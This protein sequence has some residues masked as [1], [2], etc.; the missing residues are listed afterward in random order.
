M[1]QDWQTLALKDLAE[2]DLSYKEIGEKYGRDRDTVLNLRRKHNVVRKLPP[3]KGLR[4]AVEIKQL[5]PE[6]RAL[7]VRLSIYR[8]VRN[9]SELAQE[10]N[11]SRHVVK[12]MEIGA[13]D[14]TLRQLLKLSQLMGRSINELIAPNRVTL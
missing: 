1:P 9:Y 4:P 2:T 7:G 10:L 14:F 8:G 6:H 3:R 11:V 5:S 12:M 13:H